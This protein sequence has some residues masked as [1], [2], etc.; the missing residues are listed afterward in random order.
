MDLIKE[1]LYALYYILP[2]YCSNASPVLFGGGRPIDLGRKFVDGRPIFGQHKTY[3]GFISGVLIGTAVGWVQENLAPLAGLPPGSTF[4]GF[5]LSL[6]ALIGDL[7]G[8]FIKRRLGLRPGKMLPMVDQLDFVLFALL[9]AS[10][11]QNLPPPIGTIMII[12][13]TI[14][15]HFLANFVAYL[16]HLKNTKW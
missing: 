2:A 13:L 11:S 10:L 7:F 15:I 16:L 3:R 4:S 8:S 14:P 5:L 6:G 1:T 12:L 9:F